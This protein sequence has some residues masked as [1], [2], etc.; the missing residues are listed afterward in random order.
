M[1]VTGFS[2]NGLASRQNNKSLSF[3]WPLR[4]F[5]D[6]TAIGRSLIVFSFQFI[7]IHYASP[8]F[9]GIAA[10]MVIPSSKA[11][12]MQPGLRGVERNIH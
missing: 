10:N 12:E 3:Q 8:I 7:S 2:P 1:C 9:G 6:R 5:Q 11:E 4:R